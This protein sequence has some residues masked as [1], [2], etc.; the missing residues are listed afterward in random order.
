M[1]SMFIFGEFRKGTTRTSRTVRSELYVFKVFFKLVPG[2]TASILK[3]GYCTVVREEK[4]R[5]WGVRGAYVILHGL[6]GWVEFLMVRASAW[7][8]N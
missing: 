8:V 6:F 4:V 3:C 2:T 7:L 5:K 1:Y